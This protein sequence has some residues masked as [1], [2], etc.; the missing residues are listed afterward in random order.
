ME[1]QLKKKLLPGTGKSFCVCGNYFYF[2]AKKSFTWSVG[3]IFSLNTYA[4][5]L[6]DLTI[7]ITLAKSFPDVCNE[8]T[9]FLAMVCII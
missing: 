8:A 7:L 1:L 6:G 5:V 9:T 4:P 2:F 3:M